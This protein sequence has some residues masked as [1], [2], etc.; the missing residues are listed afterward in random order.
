MI[1]PAACAFLPDPAAPGSTAPDI[2]KQAEDDPT[3]ELFPEI[4]T[5][6]IPTIPTPGMGPPR[7]RPR[8]LKIV[9]T[10]ESRLMSGLDVWVAVEVGF[11]G[12][13]ARKVEQFTAVTVTLRNKSK[14]KLP[15]ILLFGG[16]SKPAGSVAATHKNHRVYLVS[17]ASGDQ[18]QHLVYDLSFRSIANIQ[19]SS[20]GTISTEKSVL[21]R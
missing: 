3:I 1:T 17:E 5:P 7:V 2:D 8:R 13:A 10:G 19:L 21:Q 11:A 12:T 6:E 20:A 4:P 9:T 15:S 18:P 14:K 16:I